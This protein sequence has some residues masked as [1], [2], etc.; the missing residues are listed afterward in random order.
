MKEDDKLLTNDIE[1]FIIGNVMDKRSGA[2]QRG[3][4]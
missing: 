2:C 4:V 3:E 1:Q